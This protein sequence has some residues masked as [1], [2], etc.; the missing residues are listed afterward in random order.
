M[1]LIYNNFS[2]YISQ[3]MA[4]SSKIVHYYAPKRRFF[5]PLFAFFFLRVG[6]SHRYFNW[7]MIATG[8]GAGVESA[9]AFAASAVSANDQSYIVAIHVMYM[10]VYLMYILCINVC[11]LYAL[12]MY[13]YIYIILSVYL[14]VIYTVYVCICPLPMRLSQG[15]KGGLRGTKQSPMVASIP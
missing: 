13:V 7:E 6:V 2:Y 5:F 10:Y 4:I 1:L 9:L 12:S 3:Y 8:L 14:Y 15:S 11:H